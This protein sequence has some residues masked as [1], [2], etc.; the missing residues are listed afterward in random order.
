MLVVGLI[1][2]LATVQSEPIAVDPTTAAKSESTTGN[3]SSHNESAEVV[4]RGGRRGDDADAANRLPKVI[5][6]SRIP[7]QSLQRNPY[8]A[9]ATSLG[10][11]NA[12][13][14]MDAF[15][16]DT[17]IRWKSCKVEGYSVGAP[18][19]C[20]L[21]K[22]QKAIDTKEWDTARN[23]AGDLANRPD[24]SVDGQYLARR[25]LY[26]IAAETGDQPTRRQALAN[27]YDT[28]L[29]PVAEERA[30]LQTLAMM[31]SSAGD[32]REAIARYTALVAIDENDFQSRL[33]LGSLLQQSGSY[34]EGKAQYKDAVRIMKG[35]GHPIPES[36]AMSAR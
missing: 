32:N 14:G 5:V 18:Y 11:L 33:S 29:M 1:M 22:A 28:G 35:R 6:G 31:A 19:N 10:G 7:R 25:L 36:L 8:I 17:A 34:Y 4:V 12:G 15:S 26:T 3:P 27:L 24:I 20:M 13:T 21:G 23:I 2:S 16:G 30:A 9:S